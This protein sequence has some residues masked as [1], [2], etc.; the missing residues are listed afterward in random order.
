MIS[1]RVSSSAA[2][3]CRARV[4][5]RGCC[6]CAEAG[7]SVLLKCALSSASRAVLEARLDMSPLMARIS[8]LRRE[9]KRYSMIIYAQD[10]E[11]A[12]GYACWTGE[13]GVPFA[14]RILNLTAG[15]HQVIPADCASAPAPSMKSAQSRGTPQPPDSPRPARDL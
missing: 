5:R 1:V 3:W 11:S 9:H 13:E 7:C 15:Q 12:S 2:L 10:K 8:C 14:G 6:C 4:W